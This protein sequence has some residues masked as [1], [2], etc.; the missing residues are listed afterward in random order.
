MK[1]KIKSRGFTLVELLVV[2]AIMFV[3]TSIVLQKYQGYDTNALFANASENIVLALR[4]AQVYGAAV[5]ANSAICAGGVTTFDC[6]YGV[7]ISTVSPGGL[8]LFVDTNSDGLYEGGEEIQAITWATPVVVSG[9]TCNGGACG[10]G[11]L[12][13]TFKRPNPAAVIQDGGAT[14]YSSA[15]I[16][17]S[18][19]VKTSTI[20]V[21]K[22][23]QISIQ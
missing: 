22:A 17:I 9:V 11:I 2:M 8:M 13:L 4:Q 14:T 16:V 18:S 6:G 10:G 12:N 19:G 1:H 3:I 20:T 21:T 7:N 5:K 23:G 15:T